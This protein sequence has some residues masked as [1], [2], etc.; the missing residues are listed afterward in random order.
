[1]FHDVSSGTFCT[2]NGLANERRGDT[3]LRLFIVQTRR[4]AAAGSRA[5]TGHVADVQEKAMLWLRRAGGVRVQ[6]TGGPHGELRTGLS[7]A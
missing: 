3:L 4:D 7:T 1:M 6:R 2:K 5:A